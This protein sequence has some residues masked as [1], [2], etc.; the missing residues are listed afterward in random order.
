M[1]DIQSNIKVNIDT[2]NALEQIKLLQSQISA[3]HTQ[4]GKVGAASAA[5]AAQLRQTLI[6][7]INA[8]GKFNA[9]M[10]TVKTSTEYFTNALEKNKL[11]MGEYFRYA[12]GA[13]KTFGK[14]FKSEFE[15]INKV[16]RERVKDLQTQ[17]IKMGRD[18]NGAMKAIKIRPL[19][20]D[21]DN[22]GTKTAI[23]AQ[24]QQLL[25]QLLKQGSTNMLNFGKNTQWAGRQLMVGF[26][27]PLTMLGSVAVKSFKEMEEAV[28]KFK[29]VYGDLSTG[30]E[31][32]NKMAS[33]L[34]KLAESFTQYGVAVKDTMD[35]AA[36]AAAT[37]KMGADLMAQVN[38]A[39]KLSVLGQVEQQQA[40]ETT[41]SLTNA[42]GL[43]AEELTKKIDF[44]NAVENQ[45]VLSIEDLTIAIP[46]AAP[47]VEQLGGNVEDLAFFLTAMK[48]GGINAS[49]GAN[50]LKSGLASLI[51]P[52]NTAS[53][54]LAGFGINIKAI[55]QGNQGDIKKTVIGFASALDKLDPLNR[56]RAIEQM[57]GKFQFARLSTLFKNVIDQ[58]SQAGK[59]LE[60]TKATSEELAILS[61]REL[62]KVSDSPL[63]KFEKSMKD[64]QNA[65]VPIG[66]QF[67]KALTP[68]LNF[69]NGML[70]QFDGLDDGVKSFVIGLTGILGGIAPVVLMVIGLVANGV[71]N[72]IKLFA[73]FK[74]FFNNLGKS[75]KDLGSSTKYM[76][77]E[78]IEAAAVAASLDQVHGKLTQTFTSEAEA[79]QLLIAEYQKAAR[80]QAAFSGTA[81]LGGMGG[82]RRYA[83][84]GIIVGPGTGTSDSIV[85]RV[86][87]GEAV[88]PAQ[89]VSKHPDLVKG[90]I[91]GNIPAFASGG[92]VMP[93]RMWQ[94]EIGPQTQAA[95]LASE[96]KALELQ[97][98][99]EEVAASEFANMA[100]MKLPKQLV[101]SG[102]HSFITPRIGGV[103][104]LASGE[105]VFIKPQPNLTS[106]LAE[107]RGTKIAREA[108]GL[109]APEQK[110]RVIFDPT[111]PEGKRKLFALESALNEKIANPSSS[112]TRKEYFKQLTASLVRA[113]KDLQAANL[114]GR[115]LADVGPSGVFAKATRNTEM[116]TALPSMEEQAMINL[117]GVK[118]GAKKWFAQ[119]TSGIARDMSPMEY[120]NAMILEINEVLPKLKATIQT[121]GLKSA[122]RP[123]Y[124]AMVARLEAGKSVDWSKFQQ[125][126]AAVPGLATGGVISGPGSGTSDSIL[127]RVSNGE[128]IIPA[129][130]VA[131]NPELV[132]ALV[133]GNI[134]GFVKGSSGIN[135]KSATDP[136]REQGSHLNIF[137]SNELSSTIS[138][139][140]DMSSEI[141]EVR[142]MIYELKEG[143]QG[144]TEARQKHMSLL[145]ATQQGYTSM[146]GTG[147]LYGGTTIPEAGNVNLAYNRLGI[148]GTASTIESSVQH[149][150]IADQEL[151]RVR[152][153]EIVATQEYTA[154]LEELSARG[155][156][157]AAALTNV[158]E[159]DNQRVLFSRNTA[160]ET[161]ESSLISKE[162]M[163]VERA[164]IE[165]ERLLT[166]QDEKVAALRAQG[167]TGE[168]LSRKSALAYLTPSVINEYGKGPISFAG[169]TSEKDKIKSTT[170]AM[171]TGTAESYTPEKYEERSSNPRKQGRLVKRI[172]AWM[173]AESGA[174]RGKYAYEV[175]SMREAARLDG[176]ADGETYVAAKKS[177]TDKP[178][179]DSYA[180]T[181]NRNSPHAL[182]GPDGAQD[183]EAYTAAKRAE[184]LAGLTV[185]DA[186]IEKHRVF[187]IEE[188]AKAGA[189]EGAAH[190]E[191]RTAAARVENAEVLEIRQ[192]G[193]AAEMAVMQEVAAAEMSGTTG[194][195]AAGAGVGRR[196]TIKAERKL[197]RKEAM[198]GKGM[199]AMMALSMLPVAAS[200]IPGDIGK[201]AQENM[202][203]LMALSM[204]PMLGKKWGGILAIVGLLTASIMS[205][206]NAVNTA[207]DKALELAMSTGT[208]SEAMLS[209]S[210][211]AGR[212]TAGEVMDRRRLEQNGVLAIQPGRH[213]FGESFVS[214][215]TGKSFM[216]SFGQNTKENGAAF[217][218]EQLTKQME[219]AVMS[220]AMSMEQARSTVAA[221]ATELGNRQLGI[222]IIGNMTKLLGP[223]GENLTK[224]GLGLQVR[225]D[226]VKEDRRGRAGMQTVA[227]RATE[228]RAQDWG[229]VAGWGVAGAVAGAAAGAI[230]GSAIPIIGTAIG[231]VVGTIAGGIAGVIHGM[232]DRA[233]RISR[234]GGAFAGMDKNSLDQNK[235]ILDSF[236]LQ[237]QKKH[238]LLI[239]QGKINEAVALENK[240]YEARDKLLSATQGN[241]QGIIDNYLKNRRENS[242]LANAYNSGVENQ[243]NKIYK[244]TNFSEMSQMAIDSINNSSLLN[245]SSK[246]SLKLSLEDKTLNPE[247]IISLINM[248]GNKEQMDAFLNIDTK[249]GSTFSSQALQVMSGFTDSTGKIVPELQSKFILDLS[250]KSSKDATK[251][252]NTFT[253]LTS[254]GATIPADISVKVFE[255]SPTK[256]AQL[257]NVI[258]KINNQK[259]TIQFKAVAS[260]LGSDKLTHFNQQAERFESLAAEGRR[261]FIAAYQTELSLKG[262]PDQMEAFRLW[263]A[264]N[265]GKGPTDYFTFAGE[266][267]LDIAKAGVDLSTSLDG[268]ASSTNETASVQASFLDQIVKG[269]R[270]AF[271]WQQKLTVG[272]TKSKA[273]I[274][275][276]MVRGFNGLA[277]QLAK[278][279]VGAEAIQQILDAPQEEIDQIVDKTTGKIKTSFLKT[280]PKL[281]ALNP[282][283]LANITTRWLTMTKD[284]QDQERINLYQAGLDVIK[285][286]EDKINKKYDDRVKSLDE[287]QKANEKT[288]QQEQDKLSLADALSKGDIAAAA[289]A[290][291]QMKENNAKA[292]I[293][294]T[295]D[296]LEL[297]R[298][299]EL[300]DVTT[301]INGKVVDRLDL[302]TQIKELQIKLNIHKKIQLER[303]I[304]IG[305][306]LNRQITAAQ[307]LAKLTTTKAGGSGGG[308]GT[309]TGTRAATTTKAPTTTKKATTTPAPTYINPIG[310]AVQPIMSYANLGN[311][312]SQLSNK[313]NGLVNEKALS[314]GVSGA[315]ALAQLNNYA[316]IVSPSG[317]QWQTGKLNEYLAKIPVTDSETRRMFKLDYGAWEQA[318]LTNKGWRGY[319]D[320]NQMV[321]DSNYSPNALELFKNTFNDLPT[322]IKKNLHIVA[323]RIKAKKADDLVLKKTMTPINLLLKKYGMPVGT[324]NV[325]FQESSEPSK[326]DKKIMSGY[327]KTLATVKSE[328]QANKDNVKQARLYLLGQGI[329]ANN[330]D[331][332]LG[333]S[334]PFGKKVGWSGGEG[335]ASGGHILGAGTGT[336]DSIPAMLSNGEYVVR[337][338]AVK[339]IGV[340]TL[341]KLNH[342][343]KNN[344]AAGGMARYAAG[345]LSMYADGGMVIPRFGS[346]GYVGMMPRFG[347]GGLANLHQREYVLQKSAIDRIGIGSLNAMN[348]GETSM[349]DCV[350]NYNINLNVS[351]MSNE[352]DIADAVLTQIRRLDSQR[353]R[354][355]N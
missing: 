156:V 152:N 182:T 187:N 232:E 251:L 114:G 3:F 216:S 313:N 260:I 121:M 302:E 128:A 162:G 55:V 285:D 93:P 52:T 66:E 113:D 50:A 91:S 235:Q 203:P 222:K 83:T 174:S 69:V 318:A 47:V 41:I 322:A 264:E 30:N 206:I 60:L 13:S 161:L 38:S 183:G 85:A 315:K 310:Q 284:Q 172:G 135:I 217:A 29:R 229:N 337:A 77:A 247:N 243:I 325:D 71:A 267:A 127:A 280:L 154:A 181:R 259:G 186:D 269:Y 33:E 138:E 226:M 104:Q 96:K 308:G 139:M 143:A 159:A 101:P 326:D 205:F 32:T 176:L 72:L 312:F 7:G 105:Q 103:Y 298:K 334:S 256:I 351:S 57:F 221:I 108:H 99:S 24:R 110:L 89:S 124:E 293:Q 265:K 171:A 316:N 133:S 340:S 150:S 177:V 291:Q 80:A 336:S 292:A 25:N 258:D 19:M 279:G 330:S 297:S 59:T 268:G 246:M 210:K 201:A 129:K 82:A 236:E 86:S 125:V 321:F 252:L 281:A 120:H 354:S 34:K 157:S 148:A 209:L 204:L 106:A 225:L 153:G 352:N 18:A 189:R 102:G 122:E 117:L 223:N 107:L 185:S 228:M 98:M 314:A 257:Q 255:D 11:T 178:Q 40:L 188:S 123:Y 301:T 237:Y 31:E 311:Q 92:F 320:A 49:E 62:K 240:Y 116:T 81:M 2:S 137:Q 134:P 241:K 118:G 270:D 74:S 144:I 309:A 158:A 166:I 142:T 51:N 353:I 46:K 266:Q 290:A 184:L 56:A 213:T 100:A 44:L 323:K 277:V 90:L 199:G 219:S 286:K 147:R 75:S 54:M 329:N 245:D 79:I 276:F 1:A 350:Y 179:N 324:R 119:S 16:A 70:K 215:E 155:K 39:T 332:Y 48:E 230:A 163:S 64:F 200:A 36:T 346:G 94:R 195:V 341:D 249:F 345:G 294:A 344:F 97:A 165:A 304:R 202:M 299:E 253:T 242:D 65:M 6:N 164:R 76:T 5:Q 287:I 263:Q 26:T 355:T 343:D 197:A 238:D 12:G 220:G 37:G 28:I 67:L 288:S 45:T 261:V 214:S 58:G 17:Y 136:T 190:A 296:S 23:A 303:E 338:N 233:A 15:T 193:A 300:N 295:R 168:Q 4:M 78:Q 61:E 349:G 191:A 20:L 130:S 10:A 146:Y 335:Y 169:T 175:A 227:S 231:A 319:S 275:G 149:G 207:R 317:G 21:M 348:Q 248:F 306:E 63:Y 160:K 35:M 327:F 131:K 111:D 42:F 254:F 145:E 234:A 224:D 43:S 27:V 167:L 22:L 8:T 208:S 262:E 271:S 196:A 239:E 140:I 95:A 126:H 283:S 109:I 328:I 141:G 115:V 132:R 218:E 339:T 212:V 331:W 342:A 347:D 307:I 272:F 73:N 88:I 274:D 68:I 333:S 289:R 14:L 84:G 112:F 192:E 194:I 9:Q 198:A 87:N 151:L 170:R 305:D 250:T 53:K 282:F 278:A 273:A 211:Y 244:N 180:E 173:G